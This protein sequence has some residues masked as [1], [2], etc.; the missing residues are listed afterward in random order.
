MA[1]FSPNAVMDAGLQW[2]IDNTSS[3]VVCSSEPNTYAEATSSY[4]LG[5]EASVTVG[6]VGDWAT[7]GRE[8]AVPAKSSVAITAGSSAAHIAL[9]KSSG[10]ILAYVTTI[11]SQGVSASDKV[12]VATWDIRIADVTNV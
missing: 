10:S 1:K 8:V 7:S 4:K 11:S 12:N 9:V 2:V 6:A 5:I 3:L